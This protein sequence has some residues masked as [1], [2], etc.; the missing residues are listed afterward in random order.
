MRGIATIC[1]LGPWD[2]SHW[3]QKGTFHRHHFLVLLEANWCSLFCTA[4]TVKHEIM[5]CTKGDVGMKNVDTAWFMHFYILILKACSL[6]K[7]LRSKSCLQGMC[8]CQEMCVGQ[9]YVLIAKYES[10]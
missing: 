6:H 7:C 1:H 8:L 10:A 3:D 5:S 2:L 4:A 9:C